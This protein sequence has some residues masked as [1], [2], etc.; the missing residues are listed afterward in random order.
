MDY[1]P[2]HLFIQSNICYYVNSIIRNP[3]LSLYSAILYPNPDLNIFL[4]NL[5]GEAKIKLKLNKGKDIA[6]LLDHSN[7]EIDRKMVPRKLDRVTF[8]ETTLVVNRQYPIYS[9][10]NRYYLFYED[11]QLTNVDPAQK[12]QPTDFIDKVCKKHIL[13]DLS[14][15]L[16]KQRDWVEIGMFS[17]VVG[18]IA[19]M[20]GIFL[21]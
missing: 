3:I 9:N 17:A 7:K 10:S 21:F 14:K 8:G 18:M 5:G 4:N 11:R 12:P 2:N 13:T 20:V 16:G 1:N 19:L 6:I 15:E